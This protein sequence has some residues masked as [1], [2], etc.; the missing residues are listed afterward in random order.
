MRCVQSE[1]PPDDPQSKP[2][3]L[4]ERK[5]RETRHALEQ[6][7]IEL[8]LAH[9]L[10]SVT[11][12]QIAEQ[13]DVSPRTFFNYFPSKEA[14]VLGVTA[15]EANVDVLAGFP[16]QPSGNGVYQDL[17]C[18]LSQL[19]ATMVAADD[20]LE[21]RILA[22][23]SA[24]H[25]AKQQL[26]QIDALLETLTQKVARLLALESGADATELS[27]ELIAEAHILLRI[28]ASALIY[29]LDTWRKRGREFSPIQN[30]PSSFELL[31]RTVRKHIPSA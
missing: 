7:A 24:P 13:A 23:A 9:G 17:K 18:Y 10:D 20:L 8:T 2:P 6:A 16:S 5:M 22:L 12:E 4:R 29:T 21:Q 31:E 28:C 25:L 1:P 11:V 26:S 27:E 30:L 14:A 15:K 19:F 3:G